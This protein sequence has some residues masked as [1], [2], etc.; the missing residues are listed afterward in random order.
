MASGPDNRVKRRAGM[1]QKRSGGRRRFVI[2]QVDGLSHRVLEAALERGR[3]PTLAGLLRAGSHTLVRLPVGL[4]TSTPAFQARLMYGTPVD[5]PAFEFL[6][7]R[8]REYRWFPQPW[9]A[10][11]LE[12][13]LSGGQ[14]GI[15]RGGRTYGCV[16]GGGAVDC[17]LTFSHLLRPSRG[18]GRV[19]LR[20]MLRTPAI[21]A[22]V[23]ARLAAA[24]LV[25][26]G[27]G[28]VAW[29][30][31]TTLPPSGHRL[32]RRLLLQW[33]RELFTLGATADLRGGAP[34][35]YVNFVGYDVIAH[36]L[37]PEHPA[38]LRELRRID[39][40]I[41]EIWRAVRRVPELRYDL[42]V[43]SDHGQVESVP[44]EAVC[45]GERPADAVLAA[46]GRAAGPRSWWR[47]NAAWADDLCVVPAGPN[48]NV[49]WTDVPEQLPE[50]EIETRHPG[51]LAR[52]S[53]HPAIGLVLTR[54]PRGLVCHYRGRAWRAP[55][56]AGPTGCPVFDRPDRA[57]VVGELETL[58]AMRSG[59]DVM[60][61]GHESPHG[62][63]SYLG[64]R[65]SHAGPSADELYGILLA[66]AHLDVD[67][68]GLAGP[69]DLHR[70]FA[71]YARAED[72]SARDAAAAGHA[73][74]AGAATDA[75]RGKRDPRPDSRGSPGRTRRPASR[76]AGP[77]PLSAG[78]AA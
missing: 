5:I 22:W 58:L 28:L 50:P 13:Q 64:E 60:I 42:F 10:A 15:M 18:W 23:T 72:T 39:R 71:R 67:W 66:P 32:G 54:G 33:L 12:G 29:V 41:R 47:R 52:L 8:T 59:G 36:A 51:A 20:A 43:L 70:V 17:V 48:I 73:A 65:G 45:P 34:A 1:P 62:C 75:A 63:V 9:T 21:L 31:R 37:G 24:S 46:F 77:R 26:G 35:L 7:K 57:L 68:A 11:A 49:Y 4:P 25:E 40:S 2:V 53:R 19:G 61:F 27:R 78:D 16:F 14:S 69:G 3:M 38:A 74:L 6:D 76:P 44:F 55:L 56:P 30:R